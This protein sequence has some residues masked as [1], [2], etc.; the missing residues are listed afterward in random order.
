MQIQAI[1]KLRFIGRFVGAGLLLAASSWFPISVPAQ[2]IDC[3][4]PATAIEKTT[5]GNESLG[6]LNASLA[7]AYK[8]ALA[9]APDRQE[10]LGD[11][12]SR[13][14]STLDKQCRGKRGDAADAMSTCLA[15]AF[16]ARIYELKNAA[17]EGTSRAGIASCKAVADRYRGIADEHPLDTPLA[18][19]AAANTGITLAAPLATFGSLSDLVDWGHAQQP[20]IAIPEELT[21]AL[22]F[23]SGKIE[24]L[25]NTDFYSISTERGEAHCI[26]SFYF[27]AIDG[28]AQQVGPPPGFEDDAA[29]CGVRRSYGTIDS[30]PALLEETDDQSPSMKSTIKVASWGDAGFA[31]SCMATFTYAPRFPYRTLRD[32]HNT[33]SAYECEAMGVSAYQI[34][35]AV[36]KNPAE[37]RRQLMS[38]LS[39][40]QQLE[41]NQAEQDA[42]GDAAAD[43]ALSPDFDL[44]ALTENNPLRLPFTNWGH[45]YLVSLYHFT[46]GA[47]HF[48]D[49]RVNFEK[50]EDG[51]VE[52]AA[53]LSVGMVKGDVEDASA[54]SLLSR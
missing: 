25:Q 13:W 28:I 54:T 19:L 33:C 44:S 36:Q 21:Q 47:L 27:T 11:D 10:T 52:Q 37:A 3:K 30:T 24:R 16:R 35:K 43:A 32:W 12:Q 39:Q 18:A 1:A 31:A 51:R 5:C 29:A 23:T 41:Y 45:L 2:G 38:E 34:V 42:G 26:E 4:K 14:L 7:S 20:P 22:G 15:G 50:I 6:Q 17:R 48:S 46:V 40:Q 8:N 53:A 49:W 9:A